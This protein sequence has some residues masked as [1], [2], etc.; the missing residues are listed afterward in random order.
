VQAAAFVLAACTGATT[1]HSSPQNS[2]SAKSTVVPNEHHDV[3]RPLKDIPPT[4]PP[5]DDMKREIPI[6]R[7][8]L[9]PGY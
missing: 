8:P 5:P 2:D 7:L 1:Q 9:P 3:S 6:H 4:P